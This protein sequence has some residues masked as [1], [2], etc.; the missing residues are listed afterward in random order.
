[1]NRKRLLLICLLLLSVSFVT[2][3]VYSYVQSH[4]T[5]KPYWLVSG[6]YMTYEQVLVW[7]N[8]NDTEY[9]TWNVT[10]LGDTSADVDVVSHGVNVTDGNVAIVKGEVDSTINT[11][12][13]DVLSSSDPTYVGQK[14]AFW[15]PTDVKVGSPVDILYG[16]NT[17]SRS[18]S[19]NALGQERDCWVLEYN[20]ATANMKRWYDKSSGI[21]LKILVTLYQQNIT[22][23]TTET[24]VSTNMSLKK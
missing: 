23:T 3:A 6:G 15:I 22:I 8:H 14:W 4:E 1:M 16:A 9:M 18:E 24:A 17:V 13:H 12:T 19:I 5:A 11:V 7:D 20:W 2:I 21:C 10:R